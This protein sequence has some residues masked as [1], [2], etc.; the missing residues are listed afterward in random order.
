MNTLMK[1]IYVDDVTYG[2]DGED[3][4]YELY[5]LSKKVFADGG[6]NLRKFVTNSPILQQ[7]IATDEQKLPTATYLNGSIVFFNWAWKNTMRCYGYCW[8]CGF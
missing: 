7:R 1:S 2:A 8:I 4:A 6:F 5:V 3:E